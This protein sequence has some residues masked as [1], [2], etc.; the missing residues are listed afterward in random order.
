MCL[1]RMH[2]A[3]WHV[4][5]RKIGVM[6]TSAGGH[7]AAFL[8]SYAGDVSSIGDTVDQYRFDRIL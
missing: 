8:G 2:A 4:D 3:E 1:I 5:T 6:G 7:V